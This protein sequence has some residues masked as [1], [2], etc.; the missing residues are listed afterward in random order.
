MF[1][2]V[3]A[4]TI[5]TAYLLWAVPSY[6]F[7][8]ETGDGSVLPGSM[9]SNACKSLLNTLSQ[10][11]SGTYMFRVQE[12]AGFYGKVCNEENQIKHFMATYAKQNGSW[13]CKQTNN[14]CSFLE[15]GG[16]FRLNKS[17]DSYLLCEWN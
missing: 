8:V 10:Q 7:C 2:Y 15:I 5:G 13:S 11:S 6:S 14:P 17:G 9:P 16:V 3:I 1:K 4:I 12:S